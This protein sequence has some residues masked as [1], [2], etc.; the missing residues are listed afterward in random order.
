MKIVVHFP[1]KERQTH[2]LCMLAA[3]THAKAAASYLKDFACASDQ[4]NFIVQAVLQG[5]KKSRSGTDSA[6]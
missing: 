4:K 2:E 5:K 6:E 1:E 3:E